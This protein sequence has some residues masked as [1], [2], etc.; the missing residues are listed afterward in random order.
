MN[1]EIE[2]GWNIS[3]LSIIRMIGE[4]DSQIRKKSSSLLFMVI[5]R[6]NNANIVLD[7]LYYDGIEN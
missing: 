2:N 7:R 6:T 1:S 3:A 5:D 4:E